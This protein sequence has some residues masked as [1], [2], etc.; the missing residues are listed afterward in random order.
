MLFLLVHN[1]LSTFLQ[2]IAFDLFIICIMIFIN[3]QIVCIQSCHNLP[4]YLSQLTS[5]IGEL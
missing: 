2:K 4:R 1:V 5:V 3:N